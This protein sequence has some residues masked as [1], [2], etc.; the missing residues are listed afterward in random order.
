L[1]QAR[2]QAQIHGL[3]NEIALLKGELRIKDARMARVLPHCRPQYTCSL[4]NLHLPEHRRT[5]NKPRR[6]RKMARRTDIHASLG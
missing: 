6:M 2:F 4:S 5:G 1:A 3:E